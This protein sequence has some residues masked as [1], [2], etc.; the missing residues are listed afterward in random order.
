MAAIAHAKASRRMSQQVQLA[1]TGPAFLVP[2]ARWM[3]AGVPPRWQLLKSRLEGICPTGTDT[4]HQLWRWRSV[5][6]EQPAFLLQV[7]RAVF[8]SCPTRPACCGCMLTGLE[9]I[10]TC[11]HTTVQL[12]PAAPP[13]CASLGCAFQEFRFVPSVLRPTPCRWLATTGRACCTR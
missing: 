2:S 5:P 7:R 4:L 12:P 1:R 11:V 9:S 10:G 3:C 13:L 6:K 8:G